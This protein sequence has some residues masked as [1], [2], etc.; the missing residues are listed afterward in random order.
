MKERNWKIGKKLKEK[1][2]IFFYKRKAMRE[3]SKQIKD[4]KTKKVIAKWK[5]IW[6]MELFSNNEKI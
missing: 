5:E 6:V 4:V 1:V 2:A 3:N